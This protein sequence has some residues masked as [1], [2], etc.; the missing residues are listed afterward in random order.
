MS[1][2][3]VTSFTKTNRPQGGIVIYAKVRS[4]SNPS[5]EHDVTCQKVGD[6]KTWRCTCPGKAAFHPRRE[7]S[8]IAEVKERAGE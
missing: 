1:K 4:R 2:P 8:H 3:T 5:H 7:C 6:R